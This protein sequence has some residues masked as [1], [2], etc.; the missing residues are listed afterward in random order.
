V[1]HYRNTCPVCGTVSTC[2]CP[3]RDKAQTF[4]FCARCKKAAP[5]PPEQTVPGRKGAW[6]GTW[7]GARFWPLDPHPRDFHLGD[8]AHHLSMTCRYGG[9]VQRFYSVAEHS[10]LVSLFVAPEYAKE[11]LLHDASEAYVG[12]LIRPLKHQPELKAFRDAED[13]IYPMVMAAF[14]V[15]STPESRA[16]ISEVDNRIVV[17]ETQALMRSPEKYAD[18]V[19]RALGATIR[20][21]DPQAAKS[22]FL[23]RYLE[24]FGV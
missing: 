5:P 15:T 11:A 1:S 21:L 18:P 22:L 2:K 8:I 13:R 3:S 19:G 6:M 7:S 24:L 20:A 9:A 23:S 12:D 4:N 10:V 17:D 16:A 14:N